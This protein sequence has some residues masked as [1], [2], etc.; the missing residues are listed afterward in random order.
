MYSL[1]LE[2][3][4]ICNLN[5]SYCYLGDKS[6]KIMDRD[7]AEQAINLAFHNT[8]IHKDKRLWIDFIGGEPLLSYDMIKS[9]VVYIETKNTQYQY[10]LL[11][12]MTTNAVLLSEEIMDY[13]IAK[14]FNLKISLDGNKEVNDKNRVAWNGVSVHDEVMRHLE[15]LQIYENKTGKYVQVTNVITKNNFWNYYDTLVY[16]IDG[17]G[18]KIID[19]AM[20][21]TCT[22]TDDELEVF[23][24][25]LQ[26]A[27][28]YFLDKA[29]I[30]KGFHWDFARMMMKFQN[31]KQRFYNCGGGIISM[32]I[33]TDGGIYACPGN[34]HPEVAIGSIK[35]GYNKEKLNQLKSMNCINNLQCQACEIYESCTANSCVMQ[36]LLFTGDINT[37]AP[38]LCKMQRMMY[39]VY[40]KNEGILSKVIM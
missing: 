40:L 1:T 28:R 3:N 9:L 6:G 33:R 19:S 29:S 11:Y 10:K 8:R 31:K 24:V 34:L 22:W 23:E 35:K 30:G 18:F 14:G 2:L 15:L 32:Y 39:R 37:P 5:C 21:L 7:T 26:K 38:I 20:D 12:S 25:I 13:I 4:Q 27:L 17:I 16:L 36:N